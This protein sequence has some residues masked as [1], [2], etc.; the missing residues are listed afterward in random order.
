MI[1]TKQLS[2]HAAIEHSRSIKSLVFTNGAFDL[3]HAGHVNYLQQARALGDALFL[4]LNSD[5]SVTSLKGS[6]RPLVPQADRIQVLSALICVDAVILFDELTAHGLIEAL[7]PDIY[8]KGGDY[9]LD[10]NQPGTLLPEAPAVLAY[11]GRVELI[12]LEAGHSTT[13]LIQRILDRYCD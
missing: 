12:P 9:A 4:G 7:K 5:Q 6:K 8:V 11:G 3:L 2:L 10:A 13:N 1:D